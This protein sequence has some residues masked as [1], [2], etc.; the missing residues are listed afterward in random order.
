MRYLLRS[1]ADRNINTTISRHFLNEPTGCYKKSD[2]FICNKYGPLSWVCD[3][4]R[5]IRERGVIFF[6]PEIPTKIA[7]YSGNFFL[8]EER[9]SR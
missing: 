8:A 6:T 7:K 4:K 2:L 3:S 9:C 1:H 5:R